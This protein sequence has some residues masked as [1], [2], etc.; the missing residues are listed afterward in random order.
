MEEKTYVSID[1]L[2]VKAIVGAK[3]VDADI[4]KDL[5]LRKW[6]YSWL[7]DPNI[8]GNYQKFFDKWISILIVV[9]LFALV[10]EHVPGVF[11]PNAHWFH[12]FDI[13]SVAVFTV[14]YLLRLYMAPEDPDFAAKRN[15]RTSYVFSPFAI[16]D[17]L[18]IAPFY[19]QYLGIP[20]DLRALRFL[21]LLRI[22]KLFRIIV[23]AYQAFVKANE[24]RTLR[25]KIHALVFPST[26][27]GRLQELFDS[28]IAVCVLISVFAVVMES[29]HGVS[30]MLNIQFVILDA[31]M[32]GIFTI[33][34][35]MR[36][37]SCVEEPGFK[38]PV[39][40]RI[41]QAT[42]VSTF[43][44]LLAILPFF[45]EGLLHHMIDL[46]FLRV[47]RL[48]RLLKLTRGNDAT[49]TLVKVLSREWPVISASAFIM[50]LLVV[51]TASLGYLLEHDAQPDKY[52]N[53]PTS[54][55]WAVITLASIG[56]GDI[57]PV[58]PIGRAMTVVMAFAGIGIFAIPAAIL[59]SAFSDE[60][61]KE[62]DAL[63]ADLHDIMKDGRISTEELEYIR[64]EAK[65][66]HLSVE[67]VS[68]LIRQIHQEVERRSDLATLPIHKIAAQ[69]AL[70][71]EHYKTLLSNIRQLGILM[72]PAEFERMRVANNRLTPD[73][74]ALWEKIK[75]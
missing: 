54:I 46:R 65:R 63:K 3:D 45:L 47:F 12:Y 31:V 16:I 29:V 62:R 57:Y 55:Y 75:G 41:K 38:S 10:F 73:E 49:A 61:V 7:L 37:Y 59:A 48:T 2:D 43:I 52:E 36:M 17:L 11:E 71:V 18:A 58:T 15:A 39:A 22:L 9:N 66:L 25:Q 33:E 74:M 70:A 26:Y 69:P 21:R 44:D 20:L 50:I 19:L 23:P 34:Y 14:E 42:T 64:G 60:L 30:Y 32:V 6:L 13:F 40:G 28:F 5:P 53:I 68:A 4:S 35:M 56:Y 51:M 1:D 67:E 24:G 72:D 8:E 27:G